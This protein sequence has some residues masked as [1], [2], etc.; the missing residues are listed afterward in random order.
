[1]NGDFWK[2]INHGNLAGNGENNE[3][4]SYLIILGIPHYGQYDNYFSWLNWLP[5]KK[6]DSQSYNLCQLKNGCRKISSSHFY[7]AFII[8]GLP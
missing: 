1:M 2:K 6:Q 8:I 4:F 7:D 3:H 5:K